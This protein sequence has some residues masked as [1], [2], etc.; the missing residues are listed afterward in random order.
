MTADADPLVKGVVDETAAPT[1]AADHSH[2]TGRSGARGAGAPALR[3]RCSQRCGHG[4]RC[5]DVG[6]SLADARAHAAAATA[7]TAHPRQGGRRA[8]PARRR[9]EGRHEEDRR[10]R[11]RA[12]RGLPGPRRLPEGVR[13]PRVGP[14]GAV[15]ADT[16][17]QLASVSKPLA[18]T[19]V[20]GAVG[21]KA[22]TWDS[23]TS[24]PRPGLPPHERLCEPARSRSRDLLCHRTGLPDHAGDLLEDLGFDRAE[25]LAG[26]AVPEAGRHR[27]GR[28]TPTPTSGSPR[29]RSRRPRPW[30]RR[31]KTC[32]ADRLFRPLGMRS[33]SYRHADYERPPTTGAGT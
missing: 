25:V 31:G 8:G 22:V 12:R 5:R 7:A 17:F 26:P 15:D 2:T 10:A 13:R 24:R 9:G 20:A 27:S 19:V 28:A 23:T 3:V 29:R 6:G 18:S 11:H 30:A 4:P 32:A 1:P 21:D 33:T 16:V 14:A